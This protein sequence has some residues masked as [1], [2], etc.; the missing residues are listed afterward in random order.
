MDA[1]DELDLSKASCSVDAIVEDMF[2]SNQE[3][4]SFFTAIKKKLAESDIILDILS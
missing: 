1:F 4:I 2:L 3:R